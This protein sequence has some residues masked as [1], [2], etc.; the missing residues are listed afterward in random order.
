[1][2]EATFIAYLLGVF[3][4]LTIGMQ[5]GDALKRLTHTKKAEMLQKPILEET[6][7]EN[8]EKEEDLT[9]KTAGNDNAWW[10]PYVKK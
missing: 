5:A 2:F 3:V 7:D 9:K 4:V 1:T 6:E 10:L 8:G